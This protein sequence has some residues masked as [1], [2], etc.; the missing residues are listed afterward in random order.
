M[1]YPLGFLE[2]PACESWVLVRQETSSR[3]VRAM[4]Q[5]RGSILFGLKRKTETSYMVLHENCY[6]TSSIRQTQPSKSPSG[7]LGNEKKQRIAQTPY[8]SSSAAAFFFLTFFSRRGFASSSLSSSSSSSFSVL[9]SSGLYH[10]GGEVS[11]RGPAG[12]RAIVK[13][14]PAT[15]VFAGV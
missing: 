3:G 8:V 4:H 12:S 1:A 11:R 10:D 6:L 13:W 9:T 15:N 7:K 2:H 5:R 14:N